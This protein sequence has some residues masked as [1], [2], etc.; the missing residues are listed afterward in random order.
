MLNLL[1]AI[2]SSTLVSLTM[3]MSEN[4]S[5]N[6]Y[7][8]LS[9][10]YLACTIVSLFLVKQY[11]IDLITL[12]LGL[13]QGVLLLVSFLVFQSNVKENGVVLSGAFMKL[14]VL[15]PTIASMALFKEMPSIIQMCGLAIALLAILVMNKT[16]DNIVNFV[17]LIYLLVI[18][19]SSDVM[20][21]VF[22]EFGNVSNNNLFVLISFGFAFVLCSL[23]AIVKKDKITKGDV[24]SGLLIGVPNCLS[25]VF[26]LAALISVKAIV[27]YPTYSVAVIVLITLAGVAFFKEKVTKD[28]IKGIGLIVVALALLNV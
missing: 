19:G 25:S 17:G 14:G 21:K 22:S 9:F 24:F 2:I 18:G 11:N 10:N 23:L 20:A 7:T 5:T 27:A 1:F 13:V 15:V 12:G 26:L 3:R 4:W 6:Q 8:K 16:K 28:Q